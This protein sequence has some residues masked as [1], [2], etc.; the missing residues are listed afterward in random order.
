MMLKNALL[1]SVCVLARAYAATVVDSDRTRGGAKGVDAGEIGL[2]GAASAADFI[3]LGGDKVCIDGDCSGLANLGKRVGSPTQEGF[4]E[5]EIC[6]EFP[7]L[8]Y[9]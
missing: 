4:K 2:R 1:L 7:L 5:V 3:R 9:F 6:G 8:Y